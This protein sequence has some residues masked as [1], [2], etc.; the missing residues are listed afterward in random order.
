MWMR[1]KHPSVVRCLGATVDPPQIVIDMMANG[2]VLDYVG[3]NP[4]VDRAHLVSSSVPFGGS[5]LA[6]VAPRFQV[7][8]LTEGLDYLH[9]RGV[10][11][12]DLRPVG[13][14]FD[15]PLLNLVFMKEKQNILV[16]S[17]GDACISDFGFAV[18]IRSNG[19][20][21]HEGPTARGH[22]SRWASPEALKGGQI[23]KAA[24]VFSYGLVALEVRLFEL[25]F[26]SRQLSHRYLKGN[27]HGVRP[28][29]PK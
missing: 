24:D 29:Q 25:F 18:V 23:S 5:S 22:S 9:S 6:N 3:N 2:E 8:G 13:S 10:V 19:A 20:T 17:G 21:G 4:N 16:N 12:G 27:H 26:S 15:I 14:L 1:L 28:L 7:L 11:H